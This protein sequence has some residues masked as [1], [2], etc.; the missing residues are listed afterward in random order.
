[1][2]D[3]VHPVMIPGQK[4]C[5]SQAPPLTVSF[6]PSAVRASALTMSVYHCQLPL[7]RDEAIGRAPWNPSRLIS[8][9]TPSSITEYI[10][11]MLNEAR[12]IVVVILTQTAPSRLWAT[13]FAMPNT[14][15]V[16]C[17]PSTESP[18]W[19]LMVKCFIPLNPWHGVSS[20]NSD[21]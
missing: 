11:I 3:N 8:P 15:R 12:H 1:M 7:N 16:S 13:L 14:A 4:Q 19:R 18:P 5:M 9:H 2:R 21:G 6:W 10:Y 17:N 20:S